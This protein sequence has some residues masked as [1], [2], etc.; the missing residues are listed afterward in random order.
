[1]N[2]SK[3]QYNNAFSCKADPKQVLNLLSFKIK[4]EPARAAERGVKAILIG[5]MES[6]YKTKK[7]IKN[8]NQTINIS[9]LFQPFSFSTLFSPDFK[10]TDWTFKMA[11]RLSMFINDSPFRSIFL[12]RTAWNV[13]F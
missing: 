4:I 8:Q 2:T 6:A 5:C 3:E 12:P 10:Y 11:T 1:M 7:C 9:Q 13:L